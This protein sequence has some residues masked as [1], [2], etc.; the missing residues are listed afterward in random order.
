MSGA[1]RS[2]VSVRGKHKGRQRDL[3]L[4]AEKYICSFV[5]VKF[6]GREKL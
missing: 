5:G 6:V 1:L 3:Y 2:L 4:L